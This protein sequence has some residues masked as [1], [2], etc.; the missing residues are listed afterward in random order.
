MREAG[1]SLIKQTKEFIDISNASVNGMNEIVNG[2]MK[3]MKSAV[4][5]VDEMSHENNQNFEELKVESEK[6]KVDTGNEKKK[7][8]IVDD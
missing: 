3:E 7:V 6:F 2:A 1:T 4:K 5:L 8:I